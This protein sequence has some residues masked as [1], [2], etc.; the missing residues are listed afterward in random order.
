M[1]KS[2]IYYLL[3]LL[4][5]HILN[6]QLFKSLSF[7][8]TGLDQSG[9]PS[10]E[11][12]MTVWLDGTIYECKWG[13]VINKDAQVICAD[14]DVA[15]VGSYCDDTLDGQLLINNDNNNNIH[16]REISLV[17]A[18]AS[19]PTNYIE[20]GITGWCVD[21]TMA[22]GTVMMTGGKCTNAV[23]SVTNVCGLTAVNI[24]DTTF[25]GQSLNNMHSICIN[26]IAGD[27]TPNN[28]GCAPGFQLMYFDLNSP[29]AHI[30][31]SLWMDGTGTIIQ[32][33]TCNPTNNP[34]LNPTTAPTNYPTIGPTNY[35]TIGP[36]N[37]PTIGPTN[38]PT[39]GPTNY[40]TI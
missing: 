21:P 30:T 15:E 7:H 23:I 40:P 8:T 18:P 6:G 37:Y 35:P 28:V 4:S 3:S 38:Y 24:C 1:M 5:F 22:T 13:P 25:P 20:Y 2:F 33:D 31:D 17:I 9:V 34:S 10:D 32:S 36:T 27:G 29:M 11:V 12:K 26:N 14:T 39:I 19:D 16:I